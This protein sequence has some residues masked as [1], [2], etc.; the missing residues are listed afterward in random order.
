[1]MTQPNLLDYSPQDLMTLFAEWQ[2][3]S[4]RATQ[5]IQWLHQRGVCDFDQMTNLSLALRQQLKDHF[6]IRP[7]EIAF[8]RVSNDGT[9][10]WLLRLHDGNKI[11]TVYIPEKTRG[12]LCVSSQVGCTLNCS[13]CA[14]GKEG[15]NRN[16]SLGEIIGQLWLARV[17]LEKL[18]VK[19]AITNVVMMGMGE[20]LLNYDAVLPALR[21]MLSDHAY[22]LSK[23]RVTLSTSGV[24]PGMKKLQQDIPVALAVSLHAANNE[25]RNELV[26]INKK[27]PLEQLMPLCQQYFDTKQREVTYEYVMLDGVNDQLKHA[28]ELIHWLKNT[29]A[30]VN[31]I[32]FNPFDKTRYQ[33]SPREVIESFQRRLV[34]AGIPT[35]IRKTRGD[36]VDAACGQLAGQI[37]DRTGRHQR[38]LATGQLVTDKSAAKS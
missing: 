4:Y 20:P 19:Q 36:D 32:P 37:K 22:G 38:W 1:M 35:W 9:I 16:L 31:L 14:T 7:L 33:T 26:P 3:P 28:K 30:K 15:F 24:I 2:Q 25:L 11:E 13:F 34:N 8:E 21:L 23:Y 5:V 17:Q 27:Y 12:T 29:P 6:V 18:G 10:K